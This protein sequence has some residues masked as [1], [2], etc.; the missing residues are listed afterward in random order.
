M[1]NNVLWAM[2]DKYLQYFFI[3]SLKS[4]DNISIKNFEKYIILI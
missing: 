2:A 3:H 1:P 4:A